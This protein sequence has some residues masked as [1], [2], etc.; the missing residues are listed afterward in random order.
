MRPQWTT[1][2][3]DVCT[4]Y[5]LQSNDGQL[6]IFCTKYEMARSRLTSPLSTGGVK[7]TP[8]QRAYWET[9]AWIN[10]E[11]VHHKFKGLR[12]TTTKAQK[13]KERQSIQK[14]D[15]DYCDRLSEYCAEFMERFSMAEVL[16]LKEIGHE[17]WDEFVMRAHQY[18]ALSERASYLRR[19]GAKAW[20]GR[21]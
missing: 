17:R 8:K 9:L 18:V 15:I 16:A 6:T 4:Y 11:H 2:V 5:K 13:A 10:C 19:H 12:I 21:R 20:E 3:G 1:T 14:C 7:M